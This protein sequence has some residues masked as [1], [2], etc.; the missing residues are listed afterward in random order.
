[1]GAEVY[2]KELQTSVALIEMTEL[3]SM[4][5]TQGKYFKLYFSREA[6]FSVSTIKDTWN[7]IHMK[8]QEQE[9][10]RVYQQHN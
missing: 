3:S 10:E 9:H 4:K 6:T 7:W 2:G 8:D 5:E 1:M